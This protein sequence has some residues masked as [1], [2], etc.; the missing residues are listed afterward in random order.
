MFELPDTG[1]GYYP[2]SRFVH[3]DVRPRSSGSSVWI[4]G[5][6]PGEK[7]VFFPE[8]QGVVEKGRVVWKK[9]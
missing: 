1:C 4:D 5:S 9:P 7:S 2:R 8:W 3:V 6:S